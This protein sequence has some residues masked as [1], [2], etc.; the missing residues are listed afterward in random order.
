MEI[1][2]TNKNI[3]F[4]SMLITIFIIFGLSKSNPDIQNYL[5]IFDYLNNSNTFFY[6]YIE[7]GFSLLIKCFSI[8]G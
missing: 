5:Q 2:N 8:I 4:K 1:K 7:P 3:I 6:P